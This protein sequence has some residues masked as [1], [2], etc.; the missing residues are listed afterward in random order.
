MAASTL[1]FNDLLSRSL[2]EIG[3]IR[4]NQT[5]TAT[6][7]QQALPTVNS[8]FEDWEADGIELGWYPL[9]AG[10]DVLP[11]ETKDERMVIYNVAV[12]LAGQ[13]G[14][15]LQ[16]STLL[17]ARETKGRAEKSTTEDVEYDITELPRSSMGAFDIENG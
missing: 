16:E 12:E 2:R 15:P 4:P 14:A 9:S 1:T 10:T 5:P 11:I 7:L 6:Q 13:F 17:I 3:V 8:L